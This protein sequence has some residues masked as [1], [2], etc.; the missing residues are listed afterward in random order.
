MRILNPSR[1]DVFQ[2]TW[3][4]GW[5]IDNDDTRIDRV[6]AAIDDAVDWVL[7]D[8]EPLPSHFKLIGGNDAAYTEWTVQVN[9]YVDK[10]KK[11]KNIIT[12]HRP[13]L[14][15]GLYGPS[16]LVYHHSSLHKIKIGVGQPERYNEFMNGVYAWR[17]QMAVLNYL[18]AFDG[19]KALLPPFYNSER[20]DP[21]HWVGDSFYEMAT[22]L[23][24]L[25]PSADLDLMPC[26]WHRWSNGEL[27][28]DDDLQWYAESFKENCVAYAPEGFVLWCSSLD[29]TST[30]ATAKPTEEAD[31]QM[32]KLV[33]W[34]T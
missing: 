28:N 34:L 5:H 1:Y 8:A 16:P 3:L 14:K 32:Q 6:V 9:Q 25:R 33:N 19:V 21:E 26:L 15:I 24:E 20:Y 13:D 7:I 22:I 2:A 27:M 11:V 12:T 4:F 17:H 29:R 31:A 23:L 10:V 30:S 18:E